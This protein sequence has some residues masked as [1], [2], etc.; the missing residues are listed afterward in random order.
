[1]PCAPAA[2]ALWP[3]ANIVPDRYPARMT[4]LVRQAVLPMLLA[5]LAAAG[6]A[7]TRVQSVAM[8]PAVE[9]LPRP[10]RIVVHDFAVSAEG[11]SPNNAPL[12]RLHRLL[13]GSQTEEE[14]KVG[15]SVADALSLDLGTP[16]GPRLV[17]EFETDAT[18]SKRPGVAV[19]EDLFVTRGWSVR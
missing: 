13:G 5:S 7:S 8:A 1:M 18:S 2:P 10:E 11:V 6:C 3:V 14:L 19:G 4:T 15:R 17:Q 12:S 9:R 16:L